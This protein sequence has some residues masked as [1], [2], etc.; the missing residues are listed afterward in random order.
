[1]LELA[2]KRIN[3]NGEDVIEIINKISNFLLTKLKIRNKNDQY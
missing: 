3:L 2:Q 1:M